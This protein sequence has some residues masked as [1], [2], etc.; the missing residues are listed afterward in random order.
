MVQEK[1]T[2]L[3]PVA[4]MQSAGFHTKHTS[5]VQKQWRLGNCYTGRA[6]VVIGT[7][8]AS[9]TRA[10]ERS[11]ELTRFQ[12]QHQKDTSTRFTSEPIATELPFSG[13]PF[14]SLS[15][16]SSTPCEC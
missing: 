11:N 2:P 6:H 1:K 9:R 5:E 13:A 12:A 4:Q 15:R 3:L 8:V 10:N 16:G 14:M 7:G